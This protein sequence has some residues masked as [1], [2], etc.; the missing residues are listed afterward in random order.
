MKKNSILNVKIENMS[1]DGNGVARINGE[2][3][4]V[5]N[6]AVGD[7]AEIVIIK[8]FKNY[9]VGKIRKILTPSEKRIE[10]DCPVFEKCGGCVFRHIALEE[11]ERI[12]SEHVSSV[13][14][15]IGKIDV[16]VKD[17]FTPITCR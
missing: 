13:M 15:R 17:T 10:A 1:A 2:V 6:T 9:S 7:V 14:K 4:F 11:E 5:P 12:K 16:E 3:I 8:E